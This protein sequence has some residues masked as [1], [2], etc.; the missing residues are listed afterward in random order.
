MLR[1]SIIVPRPKKWPRW[2]TLCPPYAVTM[3]H[4]TSI[5]IID[6]Q[7]HLFQIMMSDDATVMCPILV[8]GDGAMMMTILTKVWWCQRLVMLWPAT[9]DCGD[10][11]AVVVQEIVTV[12]KEVP[13][14]EDVLREHRALD[15]DTTPISPSITTT[16][17]D[18]ARTPATPSHDGMSVA[19]SPAQTQSQLP[20]TP[21]Q[22]STAL[23]AELNQSLPS[24]YDIIFPEEGLWWVN[25]EVLV[26]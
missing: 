12:V 3:V 4:V 26:L 5:T 7:S 17:S 14:L 9:D 23:M 19:P 22:A 1:R 21:S 15:D 16:Q 25:N 6:S 11:D 13:R 20:S 10:A 18:G 24:F 8:L 2:S